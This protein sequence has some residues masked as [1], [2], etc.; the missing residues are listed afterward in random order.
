MQGYRERANRGLINA[1]YAISL[2]NRFNPDLL[3]YVPTYTGYLKKR[4]RQQGVP[5]A[6]RGRGG[7]GGRG[8]GGSEVEVGASNSPSLGR[9]REAM[10][11][12]TLEQIGL[13]GEMTTRPVRVVQNLR[14]RPRGQEVGSRPLIEGAGTSNT[15]A[16]PLEEPSKKRTRIEAGDTSLGKE[17]TIEIRDEEEEKDRGSV[18]KESVVESMAWARDVPWALEFRHYSGHLIHHADSASRNIGTAYKLLCSCVLPRDAKLVTG[19]TN[20]LVGE[21]AQSLLNV[22]LIIPS[23]F[24]LLNAWLFVM[25]LPFLLVGW[26]SGFGYPREVQ[27]A[28]LGD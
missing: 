14:R 24:P 23:F 27:R 10:D 22:R 4:P 18:G 3:D 6:G 5:R 15:T 7:R 1:A 9:I 19:S 17:E 11:C 8:R 13:S 2:S 28:G 26:H 25:F 21:L 20:D 12:E 16:I